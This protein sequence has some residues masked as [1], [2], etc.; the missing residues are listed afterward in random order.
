MSS[1][2]AD[3]MAYLE[4]LNFVHRD[5]ACRNCLVGSD[6]AVKIG[7]FGMA[8]ALYSL[9]YYRIEGQF[10]LPIRWMAWE[11]ILMV[12]LMFF[13]HK[14]KMHA[15]YLFSKGKFCCKSDVWA[16]GVTLWEIMAYA[17]SQPFSQL[18]DEEM[19]ANIQH[20]LH[21]GRLQVRFT[22]FRM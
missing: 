1:Q 22:A 8:R 10:V 7:D 19:I 15:I 14:H 2:I 16:F 9:D 13:S 11:S 5:L 20:M 17:E 4:S 6:L 18:T 21:E 3:G 12:Q